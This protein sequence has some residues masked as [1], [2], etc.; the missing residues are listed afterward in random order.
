MSLPASLF[1]RRYCVE[2]YSTMF[3]F[4]FSL[5]FTKLICEFGFHTVDTYPNCVLIDGSIKCVLMLTMWV[6][7][8]GLNTNSSI[9]YIFYMRYMKVLYLGLIISFTYTTLSK[10]LFNQ[11]YLKASICNLLWLERCLAID[12]WRIEED[13]K[14]KLRRGYVNCLLYIFKTLKTCHLFRF[15]ITLFNCLHRD[16]NFSQ[17]KIASYIMFWV[18][19][20]FHKLC[21]RW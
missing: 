13:L 15:Q 7:S 16:M 18:F 3:L 21:T 8:L 19:F 10:V 14:S 17:N 2:K 5:F 12:I 6:T 1:H 4:H 20:C 11:I 9:L